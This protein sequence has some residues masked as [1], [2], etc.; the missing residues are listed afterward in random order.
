MRVGDWILAV[1]NPFGL[2]GTVEAGIVGAS[3]TVDAGRDD[4][5][6]KSIRR[7]TAATRAGQMF[8]MTGEVIGINTNDL[9]ATGG[10]SAG[11]GFAIPS[12]LRSPPSI[13]SF[14]SASPNAAGS[15]SASKK[16]RLKLLDCSALKQPRVLWLPPSPA[17]RSCCQ[18]RD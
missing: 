2:G 11:I 6:I 7:S 8:D 12:N 5:F 15:A 3:V 4:D 1:G 9:L 18:K 10:I 17:G 13:S 14:N 16:L